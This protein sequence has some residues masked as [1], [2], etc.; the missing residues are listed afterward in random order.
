MSSARKTKDQSCYIQASL[1]S[2]P[3]C[4]QRH[5]DA[6]NENKLSGM[7]FSDINREVILY[8]QMYEDVSKKMLKSRKLEE[9]SNFEKKLLVG[10]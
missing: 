2:L 4:P 5:F 6:T 10:L 9:Q 1:L 3:L 7:E 8:I